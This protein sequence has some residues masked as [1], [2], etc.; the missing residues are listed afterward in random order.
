M[1]AAEWRR[2]AESKEQ[3]G[4]WTPPPPPSSYSTSPTSTSSPL[5]SHNKKRRRKAAAGGLSI[6]SQAPWFELVTVEALR[7]EHPAKWWTF[8]HISTSLIATVAQYVCY[9]DWTKQVQTG[10]IA[11]VFI[12]AIPYAF[13]QGYHHLQPPP[14]QAVFN[15]MALLLHLPIIVAAYETVD[16]SF[17]LCISVLLALWLLSVVWHALVKRGAV[18]VLLRT[19]VEVWY[20]V[21]FVHLIFRFVPVSPL[22]L[23]GVVAAFYVRLVLFARALLSTEPA[24]DID[25]LHLIRRLMRGIAWTQLWWLPPEQPHLIEAAAAVSEAAAVKVEHERTSLS[26][27]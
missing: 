4:Q 7:A 3:P 25:R 12:L 8:H 17:R 18:R 15:V 9:T 27:P 16:W 10:T 2:S 21:T 24:A 5:P 11:L 1:E 6:L 20:S 22:P 14:L 23:V 13:G 26:L 19:L